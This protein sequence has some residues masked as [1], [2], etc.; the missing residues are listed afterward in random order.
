MQIWNQE[1]EK[2]QAKREEEETMRRF[3]ADRKKDI[4]RQISDFMQYAD[5]SIQGAKT[6]F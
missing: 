3:I 2:K 1:K 6:V 5:K 4:E